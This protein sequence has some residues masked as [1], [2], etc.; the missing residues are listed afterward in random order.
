MSQCREKFVT[1]G[2]TDEDRLI[3]RTSRGRSNKPHADWT[4]LLMK[5]RKSVAN[6]RVNERTNARMNERTSE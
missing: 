5:A 4:Y 1:D 6:K 3:H 2:Q